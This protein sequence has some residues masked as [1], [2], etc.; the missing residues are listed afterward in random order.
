M[1]QFE[2]FC[3]NLT[4]RIWLRDS[5]KTWVILAFLAV[6]V[7]AM[8]QF[9]LQTA[10]QLQIWPAIPAPVSWRMS[11][12]NFRR[13]VAIAS[14]V[15]LAI[16]LSANITKC[17]CLQP[18]IFHPVLKENCPKRFPAALVL[19]IVITMWQ[20]SSMSQIHRPDLTLA[21]NHQVRIILMIAPCTMYFCIKL[22]HD[23]FIDQLYLS[24]AVHAWLC[25]VTT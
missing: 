17:T 5:R 13:L 11:L 23:R 2:K 19:Y 4:F 9:M 7:S 1:P 22:I 14:N 6:E 21:L 20:M 8:T 18:S 10:A 25:I 24:L 12:R 15:L 16:A 3:L